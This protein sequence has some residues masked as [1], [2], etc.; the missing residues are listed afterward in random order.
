MEHITNRRN[1]NPLAI[2]LFFSITIGS[3]NAQ[4]QQTETK[5]TPQQMVDALH[6]VFGKHPNAR[7]VHAKGIILEGNFTP[8]AEAKTITKAKHLQSGTIPVIVRF[9]DF[10]GIPDIP[11]TIGAANPRGFAIKF[12]MPDQTSTDIVAHSFN[13]FPV[14]TTDEFREL[15]TSIAESQH[16]TPPT[17]LDQF[18]GTHPIAKAFFTTQKP[19]PVSYATLSYFGVNSFKLTNAKGDSEYIRYQFIPESGEKFLTK[20]QLPNAGPDYLQK[21]IKER[22]AKMPVKIRFYA[23]I[24]TA[25]DKIANPSIAWSDKNKRVFLGT[26]TINRLNTNTL[27][28]DKNLSFIPNNLVDGIEA[29]DPML[30]DRSK[31][32]PISVKERRENI[33]N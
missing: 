13:G 6:A 24:A 21:E 26:I 14:A 8:S 7:A 9:S 3:I 30:K 17:P 4:G 16:A 23:Q 28:D 27:E 2:F 11:D 12:L 31:A 29:A 32:Y 20:Q 1:K 15:L 10:T 5:S 33:Q 19:A 25:G 18:L 22:V